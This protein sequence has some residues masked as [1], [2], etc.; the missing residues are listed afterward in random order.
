MGCEKRDSQTRRSGLPSAISGNPSLPCSPHII[1]ILA[2][3]GRVFP[4]WQQAEAFCRELI[5]QLASVPSPDLGSESTVTLVVRMAIAGQLEGFAVTAYFHARASKSTSAS[6]N[7]AAVMTA[8]A[9]AIPAIPTASA[10]P[11]NGSDTN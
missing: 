1:D 7:L 2:T 5:A 8:F 6:T 9:N 3:E 10:K 4:Q 11:I